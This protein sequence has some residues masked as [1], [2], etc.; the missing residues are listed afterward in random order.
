MIL[1]RI[2]GKKNWRKCTG[3]VCFRR[4]TVVKRVNI[5]WILRAI[6]RGIVHC[7]QNL[8]FLHVKT[9]GT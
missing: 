3:L 7:G 5:L 1:K 2:L 6:E 4:G 8:E 9:G